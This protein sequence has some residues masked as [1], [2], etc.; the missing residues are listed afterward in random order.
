MADKL[1]LFPVMI[2]KIT[3]SVEAFG[4]LNLMNKPIKS[5]KVHKVVKTTNKKIIYKT[6]VSVL[7]DNYNTNSEL[8]FYGCRHHPWFFMDVVIL[9]CCRARVCAPPPGRAASPR[10]RCCTATAR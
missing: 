1:M 2:R 6:N 4:T 8:H 9:G 10:G 5:I 3:P 7:P